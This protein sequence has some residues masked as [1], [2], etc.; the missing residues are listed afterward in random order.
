MALVN[1]AAKV[2]VPERFDRR[3]ADVA[4]GFVRAYGLTISGRTGRHCLFH[5]TCSRYADR[6]LACAGWNA[7]TK[8]AALRLRR[9]G[10]GYTMTTDVRGRVTLTT[11]D[12]IEFE[13]EMLAPWLARPLADKAVSF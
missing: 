12:G 5:E 7:G 13:H 1:L 8:T 10:G 2:T 4:R 9:C 11:G 3:A 6:A